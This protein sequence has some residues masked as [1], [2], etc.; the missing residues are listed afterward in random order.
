[1]G[2]PLAGSHLTKPILDSSPSESP[3]VV[4]WLS[5]HPSP[6]SSS[7]ALLSL[8]PGLWS[9]LTEA[10][11]EQMEL[12]GLGDEQKEGEREGRGKETKKE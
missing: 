8:A 5:L 1:M 11:D 6:L 4:S 10:E 2:Y 3:I 7:P 9:P 12:D